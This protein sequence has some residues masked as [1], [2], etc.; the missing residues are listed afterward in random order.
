M[1]N[2]NHSQCACAL[3]ACAVSRVFR[4][5]LT[6]GR[7][8][9]INSCPLAIAV[10]VINVYLRDARVLFDNSTRIVLGQDMVVHFFLTPPDHISCCWSARF[11]SQLSQR[12]FVE[13]T[14]Q[15]LSVGSRIVRRDAVARHGFGA[16]VSS[17]RPV[18]CSVKRGHPI[19]T[20]SH[21]TAS[22]RR[23]RQLVIV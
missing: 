15:G 2:P 10:G 16:T 13:R 9:C 22:Y 6:A 12:F 7:K 17:S 19:V 4:K 23:C 11:A 14:G 21:Q 20:C 1:Q 18:A 5:H 8:R 3:A